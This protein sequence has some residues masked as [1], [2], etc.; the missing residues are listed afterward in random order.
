[1]PLVGRIPWLELHEFQGDLSGAS[2]E[3]AIISFFNFPKARLK[4]TNQYSSQEPI[5]LHST[6][7]LLMLD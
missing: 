7:P 6:F 3:N 5:Q 2:E 1:M 4:S